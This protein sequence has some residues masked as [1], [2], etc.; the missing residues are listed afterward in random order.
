MKTK[1]NSGSCITCATILKLLFCGSTTCHTTNVVV[2]IVWTVLL[3]WQAFVNEVEKT[4]K[5]SSWLA[6]M[7]RNVASLCYV[8]CFLCSILFN[9]IYAPVTDY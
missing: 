8:E 9:C 2:E 6:A 1:Q 5:N 4:A 3:M 7:M